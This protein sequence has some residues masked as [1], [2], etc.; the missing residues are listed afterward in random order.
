MA[1]GPVSLDHVV[2]NFSLDDGQSEPP[3]VAALHAV[4]R[5]LRNA[6]VRSLATADGSL[7][8][9]V[10]PISAYAVF[11]PE[12]PRPGQLH[13][14]SGFAAIRRAGGELVLE[15]PL[16]HHRVELHGPEVGC[17]AARLGTP[18]SVESLAAEWEGLT[19]GDLR[20]VLAYLIAA[21]IVTTADPGEGWGFGEDNDPALARWT[22]YEL[23]LHARSRLGRHDLPFGDVHDDSAAAPPGPGPAR[24]RRMVLHTPDVAE[25]IA[26][27]PP[28]STVM[29]ERRSI[30]Q[31]GPSPI[32]VSQ[33]GALLHRATRASE[34][35]RPYP[36]LGGAY[37][38]RLYLLVHACDGLAPGAY[39]YTPDTH[40]LEVVT[41]AAG[42]RADV[43]H[44]AQA[45]AGLP[46]PPPVLI[47]MTAQLSR[48]ATHTGLTY[49]CILKEVGALQQTLY[50]ICTAMG[51]APCALASGDSDASARALGLDWVS[52]PSVGEFIVG[53]KND[54]FPLGQ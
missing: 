28:L 25:L 22:P 9:S 19:E 23:L 24:G 50:L 13:R 38:L 8:L 51:L 11:Q 31:Y 7:L 5:R 54:T 21:G 2:P 20:R 32:T 39:H 29:A 52:E 45:F 44:Q 3:E 30:R 18:I 42:A 1:L 34:G 46:A 37:P 17:L 36:S 47:V 12:L 15:S 49:S 10:V 26:T 14:L 35:H 43:L 48:I 16:S 33:I 6:T 40:E 4:L 53:P 41:G 27:D